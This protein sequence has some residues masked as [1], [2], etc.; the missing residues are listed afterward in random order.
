VGVKDDGS[1]EG[2]EGDVRGKLVG[3]NEELETIGT[4]VGD[5]I[6]GSGVGDVEGE[7]SVDGDE[8]DNGAL[9]VSLP[10]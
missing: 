3:D 1:K 9:V 10:S 7:R 8:D 6:N 5:D 4:A 2:G